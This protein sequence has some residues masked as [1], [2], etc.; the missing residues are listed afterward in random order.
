MQL[1]DDWKQARNNYAKHQV[2]TA[3]HYGVTSKHYLLTEQKWAEIDAEWKKNHDLSKAH[4]AAIGEEIEATSPTEPEPL[5]KMPTLN[6][7]KSVGKFPKLGDED[8]V[9]PM[10]QHNASPLFHKP[11]SR[12]RAFFKFL[13]DFRFPGSL[14]GRSSVG[15]RSH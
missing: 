3:E 12:K 10:V 9:G 5:S 11:P 1:M 14:L 6:D 4:A 8:I 2:R 15:V 13:S 7:P